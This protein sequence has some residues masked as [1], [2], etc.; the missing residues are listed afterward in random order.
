MSAIGVFLQLGSCAVVVVGVLAVLVFWLRAGDPRDINQRGDDLPGDDLPGDDMLSDDLSVGGLR[1]WS[2]RGS[3]E[4][5]RSRS[6]DAVFWNCFLALALLLPCVLIPAIYSPVA[7]AGMAFLA[8]GTAVA[9]YLGTPAAEDFRHRRRA[10]RTVQRSFVPATARHEA[11]LAR[12]RCYELELGNLI[13]FPAMSDVRQPETARLFRAMREAD[14]HRAA[15]DG[16]YVPA[17]R[18]LELALIAA[19]RAAGVSALWACPLGEAR[20]G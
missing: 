1:V 17:V 3:A 11:A 9:A 15:A 18:R 19:E 16:E 20:Q 4:K 6:G 14:V 2:L 12:W 10:R 13:D 7:G 5:G 8:A